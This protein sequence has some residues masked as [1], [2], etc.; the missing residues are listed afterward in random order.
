MLYSVGVVGLDAKSP[1]MW[2]IRRLE[3]LCVEL[4]V[5]AGRILEN[6]RCD[7]ESETWPLLESQL[8][9]DRRTARLNLLISPH[10][11][12]FNGQE[13]EEVAAG[14]NGR[15]DVF[16][17]VDNIIV[18]KLY[19]I[20][21]AKAGTHTSGREQWYLESRLLGREFI[22]DGLLQ[23]A[24]WVFYRA[25]ESRRGLRAITEAEWDLVTNQHATLIS[26]ALTD[27]DSESVDF[28]RS[29]VP[30]RGGCIIIVRC[31]C[32]CACVCPGGVVA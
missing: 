9:V 12:D 32:A 5:T 24:A 19:H 18:L 13:F 11:L 20:T 26:T 30:R 22:V 25:F 23:K 17:L 4:V 21:N 29:D 28:E 15:A 1:S 8:P 6:E 14:A 10:K 16:L 7:P 27:S 2:A 3:W 31:V